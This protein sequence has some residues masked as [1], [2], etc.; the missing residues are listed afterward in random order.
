MG[1]Q[2][3]PVG[4]KGLRRQKEDGKDMSVDTLKYWGRLGTLIRRKMKVRVSPPRDDKIFDFESIAEAR[5]PKNRGEKLSAEHPPECPFAACDPE[6]ETCFCQYFPARIEVSDAEA[7]ACVKHLSDSINTDRAFLLD[8]VAQNA[9]WLVGRWKKKSVAKRMDLLDSLSRE[10]TTEELQKATTDE[11]HLGV[12]LHKRKWGAVELVNRRSHHPNN[13][14]DLRRHLDKANTNRDVIDKMLQH[15]LL[16]F[17]QVKTCDMQSVQ[18]LTTWLL[19][20][21]DIESLS[22]DPMLFLQLL[23]KRTTY[24]PEAWM[25]FDNIQIRLSEN[26]QTLVPE[27]NKHCV[28]MSGPKYGAELVPW[29]ASRCHRWEIVGY[30]KAKHILTAQRAMMLLLREIVRALLSERQTSV[31]GA[32]SSAPSIPTTEAGGNPKWNLLVD[33]GFTSFGKSPSSQHFIRGS[34]KQPFSAPPT[35]DAVSALECVESMYR[36]AL[37][38]LELSQT[39]PAFL[40]LAVRDL[41]ASAYFDRVDSESRWNWFAD[42]VLCSYYRRFVWWRQML[43]ECTLLVESYQAYQAQPTEVTRKAYEAGMLVVH[44]ISTEHLVN[45]MGWVDYR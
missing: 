27:F 18:Y 4:L 19:P 28:N 22:E 9:D 37:D 16:D 17:I 24:S 10:L 12:R 31:G 15:K 38:E 5:F 11:E 14:V 41:A 26:W 40:Q 23:H 6:C 13:D 1:R 44:S 2:E 42:E 21:L 34:A 39:D 35:F 20:Y 7:L 45:Q 32:A 3:Y 33:S 30:N 25:M 43:K 8:A 29:E 36:A